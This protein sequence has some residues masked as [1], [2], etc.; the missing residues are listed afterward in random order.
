MTRNSFRL[1]RPVR[2]TRW[3]Q[4]WARGQKAADD[5]NSKKFD[6][7]ASDLS[8]EAGTDGGQIQ[9][10][11]SVAFTLGRAMN[12]DLDGAVQKAGVARKFPGWARD[13]LDP[14]Y[15]R[16]VAPPDFPVTNAP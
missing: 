8:Y 2:M 9:N 15:D 3:A 6:Y 14:K 1:L 5:I 10:S 16:Y 12:L 11:N 7:K 4:L 13:L